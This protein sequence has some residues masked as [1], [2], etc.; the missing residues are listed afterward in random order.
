VHVTDTQSESLS[1]AACAGVPWLPV[2]DLILKTL[3]GESVT[4][5][6]EATGKPLEGV[7]LS[8]WDGVHWACVA[9]ASALADEQ[10][11]ESGADVVA[12]ADESCGAEDV[13]AASAS[14]GEQPSE[15]EAGAAATMNEQHDGEGS[16]RRGGLLKREAEKKRAGKA[17]QAAANSEAAGAEG[18]LMQSALP[19]AARAAAAGEAV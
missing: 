4:P 9:T 2:C 14:L 19:T 10:A 5:V 13:A 1:C 8:G 16:K 3:I 18:A 7:T 17:K 12:A 11:V 15:H 6:Y